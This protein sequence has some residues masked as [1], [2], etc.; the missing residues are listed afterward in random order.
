[1][2]EVA[3]RVECAWCG[4]LLREGDE[5]VSHGICSPCREKHFTRKPVITAFLCPRCGLGRN[6]K[7]HKRTCGKQEGLGAEA[8]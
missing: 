4:V 6:S 5:P 7:E 1:M 2:S 8:V 3:P